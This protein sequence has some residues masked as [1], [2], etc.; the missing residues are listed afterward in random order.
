MTRDDILDEARDILLLTLDGT[1][2]REI[3]EA[4]WRKLWQLVREA[5]APS[6]R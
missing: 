4:D 3:F 5:D 1:R 2:Q 6:P